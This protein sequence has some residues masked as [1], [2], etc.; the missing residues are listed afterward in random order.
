MKPDG[1]TRHPRRADEGDDDLRVARTLTRWLDERYLDPIIGLIL[2]GAGDLVSSGA[3]V[4]LI[5]QAFRLKMPP[6]VI[7]RMF[8]NLAID[9]LV[10]AVPVLGDLFDFGFKA[11]QRNLALLERRHEAGGR[12]S[13]SDWAL[14]A[15]AALVFLAALAVP[16]VLLVWAIRRL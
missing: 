2:P 15:G 4:Y 13:V 12:S 11:N 10:G 8:L 5:G 1:S 14:V 7:A 6:V 9:M 16:I 3:G